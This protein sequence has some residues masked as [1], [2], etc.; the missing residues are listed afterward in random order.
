MDAALIVLGL[1]GLWLG[2]QMALKGAVKISQVFRVPSFIVGVTILS[3]GTCLPEIFIAITAALEQRSEFVH[4]PGVIFGNA[5]GATLGQGTLILGIAGLFGALLLT[6]LLRKQSFMMPSALLL[7]LFMVQDG[8]LSVREGALLI[9]TYAVFLAHG[10]VHSKRKMPTLTD[11]QNNFFL[12]GIQFAVGLGLVLFASRLT[13]D[14]AINLSEAY[15]VSQTFLGVFVLGLGTSLPELATTAAAVRH[16]EGDIAVGNI[17]GSCVLD[18]LF[19]PGLG[20]V[21]GSGL[22]VPQDILSFHLPLT[23]AMLAIIAGMLVLRRT[24]GRIQSSIAIAMYPVYYV[25]Q[26][27]ASRT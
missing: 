17:I 22:V 25:I 24:F 26:V 20:A 23:L 16:R 2:S 4:T 15:Q 27:I 21:I 7:L 13:V 8:E 12:S 11:G 18:T 9:L 5:I 6:P 1:I 14:S 3:F 10:I 19:I